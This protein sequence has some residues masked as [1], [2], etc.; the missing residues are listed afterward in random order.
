MTT[1]DLT[2]LKEQVKKIALD[3]GADLVGVGN[4][5]RLKDAP[6]SAD[7]SFSLPG[8]QS[9]I[10]W[11]YGD[12]I[13]AIEDYFAKKDRMGAKK[14]KH[15]A[16]TT[17]WKTAEKIRKFI[18]STTEY[19][20]YT[21][22]PNY[23]S[24]RHEDGSRFDMFKED[25]GYP[26]FSLKYGAVAAGLGHIGW[27]G[28]LVTKEF[29]GACY[30]GGVLTTAPL[31]P[32]PM[33]E[34]NYCTGCKI[35]AKICTSGHFSETEEE[36]EYPVVIGGVKQ[37]Y[38]KRE[39]FCRCAVTNIG[40]IGVSEDN[41]WGTWASHHIG[42]KKD[43]AELWRDPAYRGK[44]RKKIFSS[45]AT[46]KKLR[47]HAGKVMG[48]FMR[49]G[50]AENAGIVT[51]TEMNPRCGSCSYVCVPDPKKR[52]ELLKLIKSSGKVFIDD[53]G[54]EYVEKINEDGEKIVYHPPT[55]EE[56]PYTKDMDPQKT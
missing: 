3:M 56:S 23:K 54:K 35:C 48:N 6:P 26:D 51:L 29:G 45:K 25:W 52:A 39:L 30:L 37:V 33:V 24:R 34:E 38:G 55:Q 49:G 5:E 20:A 10:I 44:L 53:E 9:C 12:P 7:M 42:T 1:T 43:S 14:F 18:E 2:K 22:V 47:I 4:Q 31:E 28:L 36:D 11:A 15:F 27:Q 19:K 13:D 40:L 41:T 46:P 50:A 17:A 16:Y 32:D 21:V 8:A